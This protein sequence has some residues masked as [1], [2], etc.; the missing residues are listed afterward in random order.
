MT[1]VRIL[2]G[3]GQFEV[4]SAVLNRINELDN[5]IVEEVEEKNEERFRELLVEMILVV[6]REGKA[7]DPVEIV[8]SDVIVPPADLS[9]EEAKKIFTG[10]G[11]IPD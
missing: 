6:K 9:L 3:E 11:I 4:S 2:G 10:E 7:L 5:K 1:V 8:E